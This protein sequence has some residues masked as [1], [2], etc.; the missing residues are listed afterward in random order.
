[1][2]LQPVNESTSVC[3]GHTAQHVCSVDGTS[4]NWKVRCICLPTSRSLNC[5]ST[6]RPQTLSASSNMNKNGIIRCGQDFNVSYNFI[7]I[8]GAGVSDLNITVPH[9]YQPLGL[10]VTCVGSPLS[11]GNVEVAGDYS[12]S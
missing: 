9:H 8:N 12:Y 5:S 2:A 4:I 1:M 10:Q 7:R 6:E 11:F 3:P